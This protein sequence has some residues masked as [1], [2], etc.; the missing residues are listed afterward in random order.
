MHTPAALSK[1]IA[2]WISW[3]SP[4]EDIDKEFENDLGIHNIYNDCLV[5]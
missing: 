5:H 1:F 3:D 4:I 2:T